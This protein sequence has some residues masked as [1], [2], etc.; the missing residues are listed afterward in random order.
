MDHADLTAWINTQAIRDNL[1][2][3]RQHIG[4]TVA[5]CVAGKANAYGHGV[6]IV[7]PVLQD[8]G[9]AMI[10]TATL[11]E[12]IEVRRLNWSRPILCLGV[13]FALSRDAERA[14]RIAAAIGNDLSLSPTT[15]RDLKD[16]NLAAGK[17]RRV[18]RVH[19]NVETGMGRL[20]L[21]HDQAFE[22]CRWAVQLRHIRLE[23]VYTHLANAESLDPADAN[24]QL[25][26]FQSF[27]HRINAADI[28]VPYLHAANSAATFA[29]PESR[30]DMVRPGFAVYGYRP[31]PNT[32]D[33][34][35]LKPALKLTARLALIKD[36]EAGQSIGYGSVYVT[37]RHTRIGVIPVGYNDGYLRSLSNR[38]IMTLGQHQLPVLG[39]ISM[40]STVIDLTDLPDPH[41]GQEITVISDDPAAPNSAENL[42]KLMDTIAYEVTCLVGHR[43]K[44]QACSA[45]SVEASSSRPHAA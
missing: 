39:R 22:L 38:A 6:G 29:L 25:D 1:A 12:A 32:P 26:R 44:R 14:D 45:Q 19:V 41:L 11:D 23:G 9:V 28:H 43:A 4:P 34:V 36:I 17:L 30:F 42:A 31:G 10:A 15:P 24:N 33:A 13:G 3:I 7:V 27:I 18:A 21:P 37:Q 35:T 16:L 5:I 40:D 8:A 20:G 2:Q